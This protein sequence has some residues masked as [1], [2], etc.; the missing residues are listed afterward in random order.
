MSNYG[1]WGRY[2]PCKHTVRSLSWTTDDLP[3]PTDAAFVLPYGQG[4][5][6]GDSCQNPGGILLATARLNRF[7]SF[8]RQSGVLRCEAGVTLNDI[9][10][11]VVPQGWFLPV[12][13]G[14]RFVSVGGAIANDVHG[15]N[16]HRAGTFGRHVL[17]FELLTSDGQRRRC[18]P[19]EHASLF[20]ATIGGLGLTGLITWAELQLRPVRNPWM[21]VETIPFGSLDHFFALA[22]ASVD[23]FEYTVAW[24]DCL[25]SGRDLGRGVFMRGN[26]APAQL[27]GATRS[28]GR[29]RVRIPFDLPEFALNHL[30]VGT[31]NRLY[32]HRHRG[33]ERRALVHYQPFFYPLDSIG[34]WNRIYG[35]RGFL[36]YQC[37]V[38]YRD[39]HRAIADLLRTI[40][41]SGQ[42]SFLSVLK[43][44]G[45]MRSPGM[46]SFPRPG[47]TLALD[48]PY[49]GK[50]TLTLLERLDAI[51]RNADGAVYPAK[52][53]RMSAHS[54]QTYYPHWEQFARY[55]D[56]RFSSGFWRRVT[57]PSEEERSCEKC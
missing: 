33:R 53:A 48:F 34:D 16:H 47:V 40:A 14:T 15:K 31:F 57:Q 6:Y 56:P 43:T 7:M 30:T 52:D 41:A 35:R 9:L 54:F 17:A 28:T 23:A 2:P 44:F 5:S 32:F 10:R 22:E 50:T 49:R 4:R 45:D 46:L 36:Q 38:P 29:Q 24:V 12:T 25:A 39:N 13:P 37:V 11:L 21:A 1:S 27:N 26:H 3:L 8:D 20:R 51:V 18:A 19:D 42:G 55:V